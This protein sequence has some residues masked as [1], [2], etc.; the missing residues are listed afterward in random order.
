MSGQTIFYGD[1][2]PSTFFSREGYTVTVEERDNYLPESFRSHDFVTR[3]IPEDYTIGYYISLS[4]EESFTIAFYLSPKDFPRSENIIENLEG[5]IA[6][7]EMYVDLEEKDLTIKFVNVKREFQ[8]KGYAKY[9]M[10]LGMF[11]TQKY[12]PEINVAKLDDDSSNYINDIE[13]V[14]KR[15]ILCPTN[16]YCKLGFEYEESNSPEMIGDISKI[17]MGNMDNIMDTSKKRRRTVDDSSTKRR[18]RKKTRKAERIASEPYISP[19]EAATAALT[20]R[21]FGDYEATESGYFEDDEF[22]ALGQHEG[23]SRKKKRKITGKKKKKRKI[24]GK[25]TRKKTRKKKRKITG[26]KKRKKKNV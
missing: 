4:D 7:I 6:Y 10:I 23:G 26:K 20:G 24:T 5:S 3:T 13:D 17:V 14:E 25:K 1:V 19:A 12:T 18:K 21:S 2:F 15:K 9:L 8:G 22:S 11:Y 16:L